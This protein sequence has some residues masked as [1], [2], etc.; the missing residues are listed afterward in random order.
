MER[1]RKTK[2]REEEE[3]H[4]WGEEE[5]KEKQR[6]RKGGRKSA[7]RKLKKSEKPWGKGSMEFISMPSTGTKHGISDWKHLLN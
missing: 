5:K 1:G 7:E 4:N 2:K 3:G 6:G